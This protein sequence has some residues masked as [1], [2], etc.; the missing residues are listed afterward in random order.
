MTYIKIGLMCRLKQIVCWAETAQAK[1]V[2][3]KRRMRLTVTRNMARTRRS[4]TNLKLTKRSTRKALAQKSRTSFI[5]PRN[6]VSVNPSKCL[7][8]FCQSK[9]VSLGTLCFHLYFQ[10]AGIQSLRPVMKMSILKLG[11]VLPPTMQH[12]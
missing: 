1:R 2:T 12:V 8:C 9:R 5:G 7:G 4:M 3:L 10:E 11:Y 6:E